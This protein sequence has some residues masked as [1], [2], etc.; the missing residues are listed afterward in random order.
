MSFASLF[1]MIGCGSKVYMGARYHV[2]GGV[3]NST[4]YER[5]V[6]KY[7]ASQTGAFRFRTCMHVSGKYL[8]SYEV[9]LIL[10]CTTFV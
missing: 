1:S 2:C 10:Q 9:F 8:E 3:G 5:S 7:T 4:V 6:R